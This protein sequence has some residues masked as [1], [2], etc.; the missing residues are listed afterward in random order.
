VHRR[1]LGIT[2]TVEVAQSLFRL[3]A[4]IKHRVISSQF[5]QHTELLVAQIRGVHEQR[6]AGVLGP[7]GVV[8]G[9]HFVEPRATQA[10]GWRHAP[11]LDPRPA[12]S[13][14]DRLVGEGDEMEGIDARTNVG[15]LHGGRVLEGA[16]PIEDDGFEFRHSLWA[17]LVEERHERSAFL[18]SGAQTT[19]PSRSW[20]ATT[21]K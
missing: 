6:P 13:L 9:T 8:A 3:L 1:V 11:L 4:A 15:L 17:Q 19:R 5:V 7:A 10:F 20:S 12:A 18:P 21:V 16:S 2:Q 14:V